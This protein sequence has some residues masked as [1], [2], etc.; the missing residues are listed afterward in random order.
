MDTA[1]DGTIAAIYQAGA[2]TR[3]WGGVLRQITDQF[4]MLECQ[5][6]GVAKTTGGVLFSHASEGSPV[7]SEIAYIRTYH[8]CDP[9]SLLSC[10]VHW[11]N[12]CLTKT[13]LMLEPHCLNPIT[14][15]F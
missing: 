6:I 3:S 15:I 2:C 11:A 14:E 9:R 5:M 7:D 1:L 12:G 4:G 13:S 8:A 10:K